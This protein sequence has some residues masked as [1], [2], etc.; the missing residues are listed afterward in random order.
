MAPINSAQV[1]PN[2][3]Y[4]LSDKFANAATSINAIIDDLLAVQQ[5]SSELLMEFIDLFVKPHL[6]L[7]PS[8][9]SSLASA[10]MGFF[11]P[12]SRSL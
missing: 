12:S 3:E 10:R 6:P 1:T 7:V 8:A 2:Q 4:N 11:V 9:P 5:P